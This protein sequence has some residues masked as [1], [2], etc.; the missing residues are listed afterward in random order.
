MPDA[1]YR[2][3]DNFVAGEVEHGAQIKPAFVGPASDHSTFSF[4]RERLL[5]EAIAPQFFEYTMLLADTRVRQRR[6]LSVDG[7]PPEP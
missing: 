4:N 3:S 6:A 2:S 1:R 5:D 7:E